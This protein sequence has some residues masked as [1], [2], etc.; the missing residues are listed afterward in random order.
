MRIDKVAGDLHF[1]C[2]HRYELAAAAARGRRFVVHRSSV[3]QFSRIVEK[4]AAVCMAALLLH[5]CAG[6]TQRQIIAPAYRP[7]SQYAPAFLKAAETTTIAVYPSIV[8]SPG[9]TSFSAAS[10]QQI[11][12]LLNKAKLTSAVA[13]DGNI[14]PA[15]LKGQSQW[16]MFRNDMWAIAGKL[17]DRWTDAQYNLVMEVLFPPGGRAV[18]G[19]HCYIFDQQ[20]NNTFS[21]LLNSHHKLFVDA[22][23]VASDAT[24]ASQAML[25]DKA[26]K[27]GVAALIQQIKQPGQGSSDEHKGYSITTQDVGALDKKVERLFI[28]TK[29]HER[30][31][32]VF[33]HSLH[34]SLVSAFEANGV[35][36]IVKFTS[37]ESD[38]AAEFASDI[39]SFAPDVIMQ[40]ELDPLYRTRKDG[41]QAIVGTVFEVNLTDVAG[42]EPVWRAD[43]KVDYIRMFGSGYTAHE[44]IRKEFAWHTTAAIVTAFMADVIGQPSLPI[45]TVT[46]D[47]QLYGQRT[48]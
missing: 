46:E 8:R 35:D 30:L 3:A 38:A 4:L 13:A 32:P 44:G 9:K 11:V 42:G 24:E 45:Y 25:I 21:F 47:R 28:I 29:L 7:D 36:A 39:G 6:E 10:Q 18:F 27:V 15:E 2:E 17:K 16:D 41:Y 5:G 14:D 20:G 48:D 43:G 34:H 33:M 26:T 23:L 37:K 31:I 12:S 40:I 22:G 19:I 1:D